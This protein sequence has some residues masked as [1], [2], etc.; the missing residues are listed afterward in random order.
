MNAATKGIS[1]RS[2]FSEN[3]ESVEFLLIVPSSVFD[4]ARPVSAYGLILL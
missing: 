1:L 4:F 3:S 2:A